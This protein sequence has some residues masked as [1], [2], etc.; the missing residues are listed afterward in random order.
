LTAIIATT[1]DPSTIHGVHG[2]AGV[3][4]WKCFARGNAL[5][6]AL[7]AWEY[8]AL[9]PHGVNGEHHHT[10]TDEVY[11]IIA[12]EGTMTL[13]GAPVDVA[14]GDVILTPLGARH[15][16]RNRAAT[17]LEWLTIEMTAPVTQAILA[18]TH[19]HNGAAMNTILDAGHPPAKVVNLNDGKRL[20][21]HDT[22]SASWRALQIVR[23]APG[24]EQALEAGQLEHAVYVLSGKGSAHADGEEIA[25]EPRTALTLPRGSSAVLHGEEPGLEVFH[26]EL[27][28]AF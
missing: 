4:Y 3:S 2:A 14:P 21:P 19:Q 16:L 15:G 18:G 12:G 24:D 5:A 9:G 17:L 28:A 10:R 22:L 1:L 11:F 25:L 27:Q 7:E 8:A 26:V 6:S 23:L 20:I 13:D